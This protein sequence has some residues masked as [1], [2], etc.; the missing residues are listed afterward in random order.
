MRRVK[1]RLQHMQSAILRERKNRVLELSL[2]NYPKN[3]KGTN[4][5]HRQGS[6]VAMDELTWFD[7]ETDANGARKKGSFPA[8]RIVEDTGERRRRD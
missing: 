6:I 7:K 3:S 2:N 4:E 5:P 1:E 8:G